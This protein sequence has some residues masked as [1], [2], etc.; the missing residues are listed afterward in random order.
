MIQTMHPNTQIHKP[1]ATACKHHHARKGSEAPFKA[2]WFPGIKN[3]LVIFS[4]LL[5]LL[6]GC[7]TTNK[8]GNENVITHSGTKGNKKQKNNADNFIEA[9]KQMILGNTDKAE[10][11]FLKSLEE[12]PND[13]ASMYELAGIYAKKNAY[14]KAVEYA[15]KS[16]RNDEN[17]LWYMNRLAGLYKKTDQLD[18][19]VA[20][21]EKI[22]EQYPEKIEY[23]NDL[24]VTS[25]FNRD[26]DKAIDV[27]NKLEKRFGVSEEL[28]VQKHKIYLLQNDLEGAIREIEKLRNTDP[29]EAKYHSMLAELYLKNNQHKKALQEYEKV[30]EIDPDDPYIHISL[31]DYY[32]K[33]SDTS[34]YYEHLVRGFANPM[35]DI[36]TKVNILLSFFTVNE[37]YDD[38]KEQAFQLSEVLI[39][40]HPENP[41]AHSIYA[42]LL[43]QD[44]QYE[45]AR[46]SLRKVLELDKSRYMIWEQ[47]LFTEAELEDYTSMKQESDKVK[48]LFP[49]QPLPYMFSAIAS[50]QS[51]DYQQAIED[52]ENGL[53]FIIDND[54]LKSQFHSYLGDAYHET[55]QDEKAYEN[56]DKSLAID[57]QNSIVLNNYAYY[58]SLEN[59][60]LQ[61][62][63]E[64]AK[65]AIELDPEN[66]SN[67]DT[68]GW[69]LY[70]LGNYEEA[71]KWIEKSI[72]N[73]TDTNA[74]VLEHLGDVL[75]QLGKKEA[76][77]NTWEQALE[78]GEGGSELLKKKVRDKKL[79]E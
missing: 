68:Y 73:H 32:R 63:L 8:A 40:A 56:Y 14:E 21:L 31:S 39:E 62:A 35:L 54:L 4:A 78:A 66:A 10:T 70:K 6:A 77:I 23:H 79:Y 18:K 9:K 1:C 12:N 19:A 43:Y 69:V 30:L 67:Q 37:F 76:A 41:K 17:N 26:Y 75:F 53:R 2:L 49:Q 25:I 29:E 16:V 34:K 55:N 60:D 64:M 42:D 3:I 13:A 33:K 11:L 52:L 28:S 46:K 61:K 7:K 27:Y 59:K 38:K 45:A 65:K 44:K 5:L 71:R 72:Q 47:L 24:A 58:L 48:V 20:V 74:E 50:F 57:P 51:E 36:D 15:E 22:T